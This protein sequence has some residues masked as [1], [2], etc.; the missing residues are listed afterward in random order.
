MP[1]LIVWIAAGPD[2]TTGWY[3][4]DDGTDNIQFDGPPGRASGVAGR[5]LVVGIWSFPTCLLAVRIVPV[6]LAT[7]EFRH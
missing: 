5:S 4:L 3:D 1:G 2:G 7:D 6:S